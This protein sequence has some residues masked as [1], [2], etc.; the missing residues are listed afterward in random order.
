M[1]SNTSEY[2]STFDLGCCASLISIGHKLISLDKDNPKKVLFIFTRNSELD[3]AVNA[4]WS[5]Q[6]Q[7]DARALFDNIK[8]IKNRIYSE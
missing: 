4:Y 5:G 3:N 2:F 7:V 8:M 6:L 1:T